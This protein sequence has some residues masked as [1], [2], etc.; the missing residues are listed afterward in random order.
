MDRRGRIHR[1]VAVGRRLIL[2]DL[3]LLAVIERTEFQFHPLVL[4]EYPA[5][6][7]IGRNARHVA[8]GIERR[9]YVVGLSVVAEASV[10]A[11]E[12]V[13]MDLP[14]ETPERRILLRVE[15]LLELT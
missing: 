14:L 12:D 15:Q 5:A 9:A 7:P 10:H 2:C 8:P 3:V 4:E 13:P 1:R 6:D 11:L